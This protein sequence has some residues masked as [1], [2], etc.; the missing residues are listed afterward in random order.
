MSIVVLGG[1][2][3]G[4]RHA[5]APIHI[6]SAGHAG[7]LADADTSDGRAYL[8]VLG[9]SAQ[10]VNAAV[11]DLGFWSGETGGLALTG[12]EPPDD[13]STGTTGVGCGVP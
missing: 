12:I 6:R 9:G 7:V 10:V 8:R 4:A 13:A 11:R 1:D 3:E 2:L 5:E